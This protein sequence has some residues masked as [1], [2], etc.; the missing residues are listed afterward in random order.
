M[1]RV[2]VKALADDIARGHDEHSN[3]AEAS[4]IHQGIGATACTAWADISWGTASG[5]LAA[6]FGVFEYG[7]GHGWKLKHLSHA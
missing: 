7:A 6:V 5:L 4:Q 1:F 2:R 3:R